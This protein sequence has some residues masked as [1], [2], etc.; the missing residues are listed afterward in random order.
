MF[1]PAI[2]VAV[3]FFYLANKNDD[4]DDK[5]RGQVDNLNPKL[6]EYLN[7]FE[8]KW[9]YPVLISPASGSI[10][11]NSPGSQ[12]DV[13]L[14]NAIDVMPEHMTDK[15]TVRR[16]IRIAKE[17]GFTGIGIYPDWLPSPGLHLDVRPTDRI[18]TWGAV[19]DDGVQVYVSLNQALK[20]FI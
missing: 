4:V 12:H 20:R 5:F 6:V 3:F 10:I 15:A 19:K 16:A 2:I 7:R 9:G 17:V 11:R 18:A 8:E 13:M 14:G 1:I